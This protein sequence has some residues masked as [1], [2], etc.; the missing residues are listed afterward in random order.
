MRAQ[1]PGLR[2]DPGD[3]SEGFGRR[4]REV[5]TGERARG[6]ARE[7]GRGGDVGAGQE[8]GADG[9]RGQGVGDDGDGIRDLRT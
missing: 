6:Q 8:I 5:A 3:A 1:G 9:G 7:G 2:G 4:E